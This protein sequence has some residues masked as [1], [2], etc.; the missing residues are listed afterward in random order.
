MPDHPLVVGAAGGSIG[1]LLINLARQFLEDPYRYDPA[2]HSVKECLCGLDFDLGDRQ[3]I[4]IFLVGLLSGILLGPLI[5]L[6]W[7]CRERWRRFVL[8]RVG[9]S[10]FSST[11]T[12]YKVI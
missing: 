8:A 3:V 11:R 5:D 10:S 12:L 2:L 9:A 4:Q 7:I 6:F 1:S